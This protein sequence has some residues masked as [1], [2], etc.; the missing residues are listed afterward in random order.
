MGAKR[1]ADRKSTRRSALASA[2]ARARSSAGVGDAPFREF[3]DGSVQAK[4]G[5]A[6][7]EW[8]EVLD[9]FGVAQRGHRD[10]AAHLRDDHGVSPWWAQAITVEYERIRGL[11]A[12]GE[13]PDGFAL[14]VQRALAVTADRA[15]E[16]WT[17][18]DEVTKWF[19]PRHT[20]EF[21]VGGRF[22]NSGGGRG[23]FRKIVFGRLLRFTWE[24]P[25]RAWRGIVEVEVAARGEDRC[26]V[27]LTHVRM[28]SAEDREEMRLVWSRALDSFKS[29]VET[30]VPIAA[31]EWHASR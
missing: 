4:T 12:H 16:A 11:R 29:W 18:R 25:R 2:K 22:H 10:A 3:R 5:R 20:Q 7:E 23:E 6:R 14:S 31:E 21:R 28:A 8:F 17:E 26:T 15:W 1:M 13:R 19:A 30:G 27:K 9:A 24:G